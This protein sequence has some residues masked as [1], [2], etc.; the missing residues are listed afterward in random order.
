M[1]DLTRSAYEAAGAPARGLR[2]ARLRLPGAGAWS[3]LMLLAVAAYIFVPMLAVLLYGFAT[4]WTANVLPDGYT[5]RHWADAFADER[6]RVVLARSLGL[7]VA[8]A[9]IDLLLVT[10]AAYWQRVRNP[11]IRP[12]IELL[13]AIPFAVPFVVIA[14]GLL[15][16]S[17]SYVPALQ[18]TLWLIVPAHAAIAFSFVYWAIDGSL[19]A[20][21]VVGLSEAART[22]GAGL[23]STILRVILPNIG[24]GMASGAILA[25][26]VSFNEI[27]MVQ[28]LAGDRFETVPLYTLNL[29]KS[30]D[31]D[32]NV[33]A[34]MT[35]VSFGITLL[36]SIAVVYVNR[37]IADAKAGA[38]GP[39]PGGPAAVATT[40]TAVP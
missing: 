6:F 11:R 25:F 1:A 20:A 19:A 17:G 9:V 12:V 22:C 8:T 18:G 21:N 37:S 34:V 36:L 24:P 13:A 15:S 23:G 26:G 29:L 33:L 32:F 7:A 14:F 35:S 3:A 40:G 2:I 31:A 38:G 27:A 16:L 4:R 30:M 39:A 5:L 28:I 10:P